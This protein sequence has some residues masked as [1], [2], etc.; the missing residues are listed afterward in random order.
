MSASA[1][2]KSIA[3]TECRALSA[4][5]VSVQCFD[6]DVLRRAKQAYSYVCMALGDVCRPDATDEAED[7]LGKSGLSSFWKSVVLLMTEQNAN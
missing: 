1:R 7:Q 2:R 4:R 5:N 3:I 6:A